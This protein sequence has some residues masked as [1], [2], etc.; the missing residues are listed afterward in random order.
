MKEQSESS[1][2]IVASH[3][4]QLSQTV[5]VSERKAKIEE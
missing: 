2:N 4:V 1:L 3:L 5:D